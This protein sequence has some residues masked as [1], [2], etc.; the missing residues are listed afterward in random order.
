MKKG[1]G[2]IF[3]LFLGLVLFISFVSAVWWNPFTWFSHDVSLSPSDSSSGVVAYYNF[4][5]DLLDASGRNNNLRYSNS[6]TFTYLSTGHGNYLAL[7]GNGYLY[8][9]YNINITGNSPRTVSLWLNPYVPSAWNLPVSGSIPFLYWGDARTTGSLNLLGSW[10]SK[11]SFLGL[12]KDVFSSSSPRSNVWQHFAVTY[13]GTTARVYLNGTLIKTSAVYG[14]GTSVSPLKI[15]MYNLTGGWTKY[16]T[17]GIDEV[18]IYNKAISSSDVLEIYNYQKGLFNQTG[19]TVSFNTTCGT[20]IGS[21]MVTQNCTKSFTYN[22]TGG[23]RS[24]LITHNTSTGV[25]ESYNIRMNMFTTV[26]DPINKTEFEYYEGGNWVSKGQK[27]SGDTISLGT[28][29][30]I[31]DRVDIMGNIKSVTLHGNDFLYRI[32][33]ILG[34]CADTDWGTNWGRD[35][36]VKGSIWSNGTIIHTDYCKSNYSDYLVEGY[37][38]G[39]MFMAL[40]NTCPDGCLDGACISVNQT[41]TSVSNNWCNGADTDKSGFVDL[42]DLDTVNTWWYKSCGY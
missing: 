37:C 22:Y 42:K 5:G 36:F 39:E 1:I 17:G 21:S 14:L 34:E 30:L 2:K 27:G 33:N 24:I 15:G 10:S 9:D 31:V 26:G 41:N 8:S 16:Y 28:L 6:S 35:Y 40:P 4:D 13:D 38:L 7:M 12:G 18:L 19:Q 32:F 3:V 23:D 29:I 20:I 11:L 25:V